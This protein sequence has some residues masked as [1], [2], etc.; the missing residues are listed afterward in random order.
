MATYESSATIHQRIQGLYPSVEQANAL[1]RQHQR[2]GH[3]IPVPTGGPKLLQHDPVF[4]SLAIRAAT[5]KAAVSTLCE[6]GD[7]DSAMILARAV[8]EN[9]VL[10]RWLLGGEGRVRLETY[11]L[12]GAVLHERLVQIVKT[13]YNNKSELLNMA[14]DR[15]DPYARAIAQLVFGGKN[16]TWAYFPHPT[17]P[18]KLSRVTIKQMF[19]ELQEDGGGAFAYEVPYANGSQFVHSGP[20]SIRSLVPYVLSL[21]RFTLRPVPRD[22]RRE[23]AMSISNVG[24]LVALD[25]L[26]DYIGLDLAEPIQEIAQAMVAASELED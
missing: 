10:M 19:T 15:S 26:N 20:L 21:D 23:E 12:F 8:L 7:G 1:F 17:K 18:G 9:G 2:I 24:M 3:S 16:D 22:D 25:A 13:F 6:A 5:T 14:R 11:A 4:C